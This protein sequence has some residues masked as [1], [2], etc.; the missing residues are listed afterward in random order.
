MSLRCLSIF[1]MIVTALSPACQAEGVDLS[2]VVVN[3]DRHPLAG[4]GVSLASG[5]W[6]TQTDAQGAWS[7]SS[8]AGAKAFRRKASS[9]VG[10]LQVKAGRVAVRYQ[11]MDLLGRTDARKEN[12]VAFGARQT[13]AAA[14]TLL[15]KMG[16]RIFRFPLASPTFGAMDTIVLHTDTATSTALELRAI[17]YPWVDRMGLGLGL[18]NTGTED[19]DSLRIRFFL[20]GKKSQL[21]DFAARIDIAFHYRTDGFIDSG[22]FVATKAVTKARPRLL[23]ADCP[24]DSV[25]TWAFDMPF[26]GARLEKG[27]RWRLDVLFDRHSLIRDTIEILN[28][29][30]THNPFAGGDWSFRAHVAGGDGGV[31]ERDYAGVPLLSKNAIDSLGRNVSVN[32]YI[33][34]YR[35]DRLLYG[36]PP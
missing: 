4:V 21:L 17:Q 35:G 24:T 23:A 6:T 29:P 30:P 9:G 7:L 3:Q 8:S 14:D 33:A 1:V 15:L 12:G 19:F 2:G 5:E 22:L 18:V 36:N 34:V 13:V 27:T 31:S 26:V 10:T 16:S 11:G 20:N 28:Q 25:C 32:P